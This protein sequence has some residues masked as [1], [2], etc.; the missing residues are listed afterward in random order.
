MMTVR[1]HLDSRHAAVVVDT[2]H[3]PQV[4]LHPV[5]LSNIQ[6]TDT[7][8]KPRC[9]INHRAT[10]QQ[11]Y[12]Q[13]ER[14]G[15]LDNFRRAAGNY[16]GAFQGL[17]YNDSDVYKW[18][19]AA[20]WTLAGV[21]DAQLEQQLDTVIELI[22]AAQD[23]DGYLN[24][25][26]TFE[27][28]AER[29]SNL[30]D[31]HELYCA[32]HL[33]QAAIA[34]RRATEKSSLLEVAIR[35]ADNIARVFGPHGRP[36]A[37]GHPEIEMALVELARETGER[38]Y[39]EQAQFFL[40]QR[41]Q[42]PPVL[43]GS[44]YCQDHQPV[45][46]QQEV[47]G[48]A[49]RALYLYS[50]LTD[51]YL[52]TG[53]VALDDAQEALWHNLTQRKT[54]ITGGVGSRWEGEAFGEDYELPNERA[55][56]ETCAAIASV[57]WNWRLLQAKPET[58]FTDMIEQ[59]LYSGVIAGSSLDGSIYFY[60]NPL[61]DRGKHRRQPWFDTACCPP[62]L[63]RLLASLPGY[64]YSTSGEGIWLHLYASNTAQ[65]PL[66]D[67]QIVTVE[68]QTNYPWDEEIHIALQVPEPQAFTLF[69][70]IPT[71]ATGA[72]I[73]VNQQAIEDVTV[74]PGTYVQL[75]R[76]WKS[77]DEITIMLPLKV[78][79][80]ESHPHVTS[81]NGRVAIV[82]GPLVYCVEQTDHGSVDVWDI[83][84]PDRPQWEI[85]R[86]EQLLGGIVTLHTQAYQ[87][88]EKEWS[89]QLYRSCSQD[90]H[91]DYQPIQITAVPY[92][93]WANREAGPMQVWLPLVQL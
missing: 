47:V 89:G 5:S 10:L 44:P 35:V 92:F 54:Y 21:S 71:W 77:G 55:Y 46:E 36:G 72:S 66:A 79:L 3:S 52:E 20:S 85:R 42:K 9:E 80:L 63:A 53:E 4:R 37:C 82:R 6:L 56:A 25:Y 34:Y 7:F 38:R 49:V 75:H 1:P 83:V 84:L 14:T 26:F 87:Q 40:D 65:I 74:Q 57:M 11:Q 68:Q 64:F 41:G 90:M 58:R 39:L 61:A 30:V 27:R 17:F 67:G 59:T 33:I 28:K 45:R 18:V 50:G 16:K 48:H 73:L 13:S 8:W 32:G 88:V 76:T 19:E 29:W 86:Q 23:E 31:K 93:A 60:Q 51:V 24:T 91:D 62:N 15:R 43:N 81:N 70:R 78:R 12:E 22:A 69:V 2:R